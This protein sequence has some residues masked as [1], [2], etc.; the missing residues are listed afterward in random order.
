MET[1]REFVRLLIKWLSH[2]IYLSDKEGKNSSPYL[3]PAELGSG[4]FPQKLEDADASYLQIY[5]APK[6]LAAPQTIMYDETRTSL[7]EYRTLL[8]EA[9]PI[10]ILEVPEFIRVVQPDNRP[11][12]SEIWKTIRSYDI[13]QINAYLFLAQ[14]VFREMPTFQS[15]Y[16]NNQRNLVDLTNS[17][18]EYQTEVLLK[19]ADREVIIQFI[20]YRLRRVLLK[21]VDEYRG[22]RTQLGKSRLEEELVSDLTAL[23]RALELNGF[24]R[25]DY[26]KITRPLDSLFDEE[27]AKQ[28]KRIRKRVREIIKE[29]EQ[30]GMSQRAAIFDA[31]RQRMRSE[32]ARELSN[33]EG[34]G[35]LSKELG[36]RISYLQNVME[37]EF[38][39]QLRNVENLS[40]K[41]R[42]SVIK[43]EVVD[44]IE[45]DLLRYLDIQTWRQEGAKAARAEEEKRERKTAPFSEKVKALNPF[46]KQTEQQ[47]VID[48]FLEKFDEVERAAGTSSE[49]K[50]AIDFFRGQ[51]LNL[52][53]QDALSTVREFRDLDDKELRELISVRYINDQLRSDLIK[54][55]EPLSA[56]GED[57]EV[58]TEQLLQS[59]TRQLV[60]GIMAARNLRN[61]SDG[62]LTKEFKI[63]L[64]SKMTSLEGLEGYV[65][66]YNSVLKSEYE[67]NPADL[68]L[69]NTELKGYLDFSQFDNYQIDFD[70]LRRFAFEGDL[71]LQLGVYFK[72]Q[73]DRKSS[74]VQSKEEDQIREKRDKSYSEFQRRKATGWL[75]RENVLSEQGPSDRRFLEQIRSRIP[76]F[77]LERMVSEEYHVAERAFQ[78]AVSQKD[79]IKLEVEALAL[80]RQALDD[81]PRSNFQYHARFRIGDI[82]VEQAYLLLEQGRVFAKQGMKEMADRRKKSAQQKLSE[83]RDV[84]QNEALFNPAPIGFPR[85]EFT[86]FWLAQLLYDQ[87]NVKATQI[88][89]DLFLNEFS[90]NRGD[91]KLGDNALFI[92]GICQSDQGDYDIAKETFSRLFTSKSTGRLMA[93]MA[94]LQRASL[95]SPINQGSRDLIESDYSAEFA[96]IKRDLHPH[97]FLSYKVMGDVELE[98][99]RYDNAVE[100]YQ[101]AV[102]LFER[103][104]QR[105][106]YGDSENHYVSYVDTQRQYNESL[107]GLSSAY[108]AR[109]R[110]SGVDNVTD[111]NLCIENIYK[112]LGEPELSPRVI[113]KAHLILGD[114]HYIRANYYST[115]QQL[116]NRSVADF[117]EVIRTYRIIA[118]EYPKLDIARTSNLAQTYLALNMPYE[119]IRILEK[120]KAEI[121]ISQVGQSGL[122]QYELDLTNRM[123]GSIH[124]SLKDYTKA[125][126]S[127]QSIQTPEFKSELQSSIKNLQKL[128]ALGN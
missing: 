24:V 91:L 53:K 66:N 60:D 15:A 63:L 113:R 23:Q 16:E 103:S 42:R 107:V 83:A 123:L 59:L 3:P 39:R 99:Q 85:T 55:D 120:Q 96:N 114:A 95:T 81:Q 58:I 122:H 80:F 35:Q 13:D 127:Y 10:E 7:Q 86:R 38:R 30:A 29:Q 12:Y 97:Y 18:K 112:L 56:A 61:Q 33:Y 36:T 125:I 5:Y 124:R 44:I 87:G 70:A 73:T 32:F 69:L 51:L 79:P 46:A 43:E 49:R 128:E 20:E 72:R 119:S 37:S 11:T 2:R 50:L 121:L 22:R 78:E 62:D 110:E 71:A 26:R 118:T 65:V 89:L 1:D 8:D 74:S 68:R 92:Q 108:I 25:N 6:D 54:I 27:I 105:R 48:R 77:E 109:Y 28:R 45:Q 75:M 111:L 93:D 40:Y 52:Y 82:K 57:F 90:N 21:K 117:E 98:D 47:Q 76:R 64:L 102:S 126:A 101:D 88:E 100:R 116:Q 34:R 31:I 4:S 104:F 94:R 41:E 84:Y 9:A 106:T 67:N 14:S 115:D 19:N 17:I